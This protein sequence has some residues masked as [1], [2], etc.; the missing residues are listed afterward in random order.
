MTARAGLLLLLGV[1]ASPLAFRPAVPRLATRASARHAATQAEVESPPR[2]VLSVPPEELALE[3]GRSPLASRPCETTKAASVWHAIRQGYDPFDA[4]DPGLRSGTVGSR[5]ALEEGATVAAAPAGKGNFVSRRVATMLETSARVGPI[6]AAVEHES[7]D[8]ASGTRKLLVRLRA[9]GALVECVLI[10]MHARTSLCVSSQVGCRMACAF[11]ATGRMGEGR[12]LS[13]DEILAQVWLGRRYARRLALP[14]LVNLVFMGM[15]EPL[16]NL[17]AV[18]EALALITRADA[19]DFSRKLTIVSTVA[20]SPQHVAAMGALPAKLAWSVHAATDAK[21]RRLVPT[22]S[23]SV[24][25]LR[26]AFAAALAARAK[27][28][29]QLVVELTLMDGVNDGADDARALIE[30]LRPAFSRDQILVNLIPMNSVA[31]AP[32]L[33]GASRDAARAFQRA[34]WDG[35]FLCTVRGTKGDDEAAACGQLSTKA[36]MRAGFSP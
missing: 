3:L 21:R 34:I 19:F 18:R 20:P 14:P 24:F 16:N 17:P 4:D 30:L 6:A 9:D 5:V 10:R 11:C 35:G 23:H 13:A 15:G 1:C 8:A 2:S 7:Y 22:Q 29:R 28:H 31:H 36:A 25:E 33:R 32:S 12:D 26:D 27:R